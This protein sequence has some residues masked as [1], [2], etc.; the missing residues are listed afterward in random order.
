MRSVPFC[1]SRFARREPPRRGRKALV[2]RIRGNAVGHLDTFGRSP[3]SYHS[4]YCPP[5]RQRT[6]PGGEKA[7][8]TPR[9]RP[10]L[11][12]SPA[13]EQEGFVPRRSRDRRDRL[14]QFL[15]QV[16]P[17]SK[18]HPWTSIGQMLT[19]TLTEIRASALAGSTHPTK[20]SVVLLITPPPS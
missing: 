8:K 19:G 11:V 18:T 16:K 7:W 20:T 12:G 5:R 13:Q 15:T 10:F 1:G 4:G 17:S 14:G 6:R 3:A 9:G 2:A